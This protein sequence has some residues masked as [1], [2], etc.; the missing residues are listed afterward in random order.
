MT[1]TPHQRYKI[2]ILED[3]VIIAD[4]I[5]RHLV[6]NGHEVVGTAISF[7][8]AVEL[9]HDTQPDLAL[10]DIRVDG[11]KSGVDFAHF[12]RG[13]SHPIP[14]IFLTS[15][16]DAGHIA[17][18]RETFPMGYLS[19]P[20][21]AGSLLATIEV[22]MHN[23]RA[24]SEKPAGTVVL[25]DGRQTYRISVETITYLQASHVYVKINQ[26]GQAPLMLRTTLSDL[27]DEL[28][29][30]Q[31]IQTHRSYAVNLAHVT[32]FDKENIYVGDTALPVSRSRRGQVLARL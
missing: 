31:F 30:D 3:E 5:A 4:T 32:R 17:Q 14:F 11:E 9:Y 13:Q 19:K 7:D 16:T 23:H 12:L 26:V 27:I 21:Q 15:Q 28:G 24:G 6:R 20:I 10:L 25:R 29:E 8:D 18:V 1:T 22:A 2:L